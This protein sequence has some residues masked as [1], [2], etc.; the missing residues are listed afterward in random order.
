MRELEK[1]IEAILATAVPSEP[2]YKVG[3]GWDGGLTLQKAGKPTI[4]HPSIIAKKVGLHVGERLSW[5]TMSHN[6]ENSNGIKN[7]MLYAIDHYIRAFLHQYQESKNNKLTSIYRWYQEFLTPHNMDKNESL[8]N[9]MFNVYKWMYS[10]DGKHQKGSELSRS[11]ISVL[12]V[13]R[14]RYEAKGM[15]L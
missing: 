12:E 4:N 9:D 13:L 2:T 8:E 7:E 15:K 5:S 14:S 6:L 10:N 3:N 11:I 1:E